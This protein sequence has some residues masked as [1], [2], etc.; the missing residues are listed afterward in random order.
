MNFAFEFLYLIIG[1]L[2]FYFIIN[3]I[4]DL[5]DLIKIKN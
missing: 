1:N 3:Y 5:L 4:Y 2:I